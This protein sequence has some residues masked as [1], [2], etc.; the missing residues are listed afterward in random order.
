M[1]VG[2]FCCSFSIFPPFYQHDNS[3]EEKDDVVR[4]AKEKYPD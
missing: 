1:K 3:V 2:V 4:V